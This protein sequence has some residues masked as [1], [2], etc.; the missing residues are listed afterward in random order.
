MCVFLAMA[1][2]ATASSVK[3]ADELFAKAVAAYHAARY[4]EAVSVNTSILAKGFVSPALYYNLGN[5]QF[6]AGRVGRAIINYL[7]AGR[8][9]PRDSDLKANLA[10][11]RTS[12]E[13]Y[14]PWRRD[15]FFAPAREMWSAEELKW[16][17]FAGVVLT[18]AF[19]LFALYARLRRRDLLIGTILLCVCAVYLGAALLSLHMDSRREAVVV[20]K[21][22]ARFEPSGQATVYF[23]LPEGTEVRVLREKAGWTKVER[24]DGKTGW[25]PSAVVE[26]I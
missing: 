18:G 25:V 24:S 17:F 11:A 4:E 1:G 23:K 26:R 9:A 8:L 7:R 19:I 12:V 16:V 2:L 5:A 3:E 14:A 6:K 20:M 22:E 13:N 15:P 10:F 21:G